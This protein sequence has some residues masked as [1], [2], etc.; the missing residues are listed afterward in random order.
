MND[1]TI[2]SA[3]TN[4][5]SCAEYEN[6]LRLINMESKRIY[7]LISNIAIY[8]KNKTGTIPVSISNCSLHAVGSSTLSIL[9]Y[10]ATNPKVTISNNLE[11]ISFH[12]DENHLNHIFYNLLLNSIEN[13]T[14]G[15]ISIESN[16]TEKE[17][18]ISVTDTGIGIKSENINK[19]F[20]PFSEENEFTLTE[21]FGVGLF[22]AARL[23][24]TLGG[25]LKYSPNIPHGSIFSFTL[26]LQLDN[27]ITALH[28]TEANNSN[29][30]FNMYKTK[31]ILI[32][33]VE[34]KCIIF[35]L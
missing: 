12:S 32:S 30:N 7:N 17:I 35:I 22:V 3:E 19:N 25:N 18:T 4:L 8:I 5:K 15:S 31:N 34:S 16:H 6:N 20:D 29:S 2:L 13:T 24:S 23:I 10:L 11:H 14:E 33:P 28:P 27:I 26:P 9:S 1:L 21:N